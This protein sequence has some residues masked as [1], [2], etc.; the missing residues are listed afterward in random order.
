MIADLTNPLGQKTPYTPDA[1]DRITQ[2]T[3]LINRS[4]AFTYDANNNLLTVTD[5][6]SQQTV[7]TYSSM[8]RVSTRKDLL[9]KTETYSYD[10]RCQMLRS[11]SMAG[12]GDYWPRRILIVSRSMMTSARANSVSETVSRRRSS[13]CWVSSILV[14]HTR[15]RMMPAWEPIGNDRW[16]AKSSSNV[17]IMACRCC[18]Q[19]NMSS[20]ER[21][22]S[23]TSEV[24]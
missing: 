18:A 12:G 3:D 9:F 21:P 11:G 14:G 20:S 17:R 8:N 2:L 15:N 5:A 6:K 23:S 22:E 19:A 1:L 16:S 13:A 10:N 7:Y 4:I 24:W